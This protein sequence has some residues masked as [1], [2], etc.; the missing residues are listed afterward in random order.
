MR[1]I[2][3]S[4]PLAVLC[5]VAFVG[6]TAQCP[7]RPDPGTVVEDTLALKSTNGTLQAALV[8]RHSTD[9]FGYAHYCYNYESA[10]GDV[11]APTLQVNPGDTLKLEVTDRIKTDDS[12]D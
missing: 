9:D 6:A 8:M 4:L 2:C 10:K 1:G 7:K 12:E 11:E 3:K 5:G